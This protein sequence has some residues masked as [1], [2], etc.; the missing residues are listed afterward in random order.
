M[1]NLYPQIATNPN[2]LH[3]A[4]D[5]IVQ[6][7]NLNHI[8]EVFSSNQLYIWAAWGTL[9]EK[10]PFLKECLVQIYELSQ[11]FSMQWLSVGEITKRGHP[12][13]PLYLRANEK[14]NDFNI[15][16]YIEKLEVGFVN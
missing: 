16:M 4:A 10:R 12:R 5:L 11:M 9:I 1:M 6:Q 7:Q 13:H 15:K 2:D 3:G 14:T 8:R